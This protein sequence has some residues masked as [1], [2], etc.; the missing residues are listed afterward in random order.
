MG[1]TLRTHFTPKSSARGWIQETKFF[2]LFTSFWD[3]FAPIGQEP[4]GNLLCRGPSWVGSMRGEFTNRVGYA[5]STT[6]IPAR[7][8]RTDFHIFGYTLRSN[9]IYCIGNLFTFIFNT[10]QQTY[11]LRENLLVCYKH[12]RHLELELNR[13]LNRGPQVVASVWVAE[14]EMVQIKNFRFFPT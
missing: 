2:V 14:N 12:N 5:Q 1:L 13:V 7:I 4:M 3:N 10:A 6:A 8:E 11:P 9:I